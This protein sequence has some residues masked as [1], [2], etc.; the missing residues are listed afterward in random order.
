MWVSPSGGTDL[1][2]GDDEGRGDVV[3]FGDAFAVDP[4]VE[5]ALVAGL[6]GIPVL[7]PEDFDFVVVVAKV[8]QVEVVPGVFGDERVDG[9][10]FFVAGEEAD[11]VFDEHVREGGVEVV[12][13]VA[14]AFAHGWFALDDLAAAGHTIAAGAREI[15]LA[16]GATATVE[17][18]VLRHVIVE[19]LAIL[20][21]DL[22]AS[23]F[24]VT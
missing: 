15:P 19:E 17:F 10:A 3:G 8:A 22:A 18:D 4:D 16:D 2:E 12:L 5:F 23:R 6:V 11:E 21:A 9:E 14:E 1:M 24:V 20:I 13:D 7:F